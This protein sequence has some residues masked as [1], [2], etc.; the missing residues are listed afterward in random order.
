MPDSRASYSEQM[1][2]ISSLS[3][4][5]NDHNLVSGFRTPLYGDEPALEKQYDFIKIPVKFWQ[6]GQVQHF[7]LYFIVLLFSL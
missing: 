5:A 1:T 6:Q 2:H 7:R 3:S 4:L